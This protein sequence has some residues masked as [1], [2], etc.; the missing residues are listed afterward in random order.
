[1]SYAVDA[2]VAVVQKALKR[3]V[4]HVKG[5]ECVFNYDKLDREWYSRCNLFVRI[6]EDKEKLSGKA[7]DAKRAKAKKSQKNAKSS[8]SISKKECDTVN[9]SHFQAKQIKLLV[10]FLEISFL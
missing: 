7:I 5:V 8:K 9:E 2:M 10:F 6:V 3:H 1:M 4:T